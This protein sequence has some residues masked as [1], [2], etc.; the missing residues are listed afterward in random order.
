MIFPEVPLTAAEQA[1]GILERVFGFHSF[2]GFQLDVVEH[3]AQGGDALVLMPTGGGKSLCY[4]IPALMRPG[5]AVVISPLIALM[6]DQVSTLEQL[7]VRAAFLNSSLSSR[8]AADVRRRLWNGEVDI[9]YVAPERLLME[10]MLE[11][12]SQLQI[13]LFAIDEAHCVSMWG[14]DFR[15]EYA[16]LSILRER[17]PEVPRIA[18]TATADINTREEI[19]ERLLQNPRRFVASFDRPNIRYRITEKRGERDQLLTFIRSEHSGESGIVYCYSRNRTEEIAKYLEEK[20]VRALAYH[21]GLESEERTARQEQFLAEDGIVM[22][23]TIAFGM[24]IDKPDVRFVVHM[25]MPKSIENYYQETGRAGRDGKPS[26]AWMLYG[27][28][29][30]V[31]QR[32]FIDDSNGSVEY[33]RRCIAKLESML[34]L[35]EATSCRRKIL[36]EYFG[37]SAQAR[38]ENCDNCLQPA[39]VD[40]VTVAAKKLASTVYRV[41]Q[42]SGTGFGQRQIIDILLGNATDKILARGHDKLS[43]FGIGREL[44]EAQWRSLVRQ[45]VIRNWLT[46]DPDRFN[47]LSLGP[48]VAE[49]L[50]QGRTIGLR[51]PGEKRFKPARSAA[52]DL[53]GESLT[54]FNVLRGWRRQ[55]ALEENR[56][57][58]RVF[59]DKTLEQIALEQPVTLGLLGTLSGVGEAKLDHYGEE[60]ITLVRR[61]KEGLERD[62]KTA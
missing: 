44:S 10:S 1:L 22:V 59:P 27:L 29:D 15:P 5:V 13:A 50:K 48:R 49:L 18:L 61:F 11:M 31:N 21:A 35:C 20:G 30:V 40:D 14:H 32:R 8:D 6:A 36:L 37:E 52:V 58:Y 34:A 3:V 43:T 2:R 25:D 19:C 45:M 39:V 9:L 17:W 4:Q 33:Q 53:S 47:A 41:Q 51:R 23:A 26:D 24:G 12:L 46:V 42:H 56:P 60:I 62:G 7:G 54:L 38:C 57:A 16:Q 55:K 28:R